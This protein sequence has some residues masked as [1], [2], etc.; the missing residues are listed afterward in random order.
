MR[1]HAW[2]LVIFIGSE[3]IQSDTFESQRR[4]KLMAE[5]R[6]TCS[7]FFQLLGIV[8]WV[9]PLIGLSQRHCGLSAEWKTWH[10][11]PMPMTDVICQQ[12]ERNYLTNYVVSHIIAVFHAR[13]GET[14]CKCT[15]EERA[16]S[17]LSAWTLL[18][19]NYLI[20]I[21]RLD[22]VTLLI[23]VNKTRRVFWP[24]DGPNWL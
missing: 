15:E 10:V 5:I 1:V 23:A 18:F 13:A 14:S 12:C 17:W 7:L 8:P 21:C 2:L 16:G 22:A 3:T 9:F 6:L 19:W 4:K 24:L 11:P 20:L